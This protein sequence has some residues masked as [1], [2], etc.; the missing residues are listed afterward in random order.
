M[1]VKKTR[2]AAAAG[3]DPRYAAVAARD[4]RADG[5]FVYAVR[6]TGIY[7]R[8]GCPARPAKP[9]NIVFYDSAAAAERAGFR[10][11]KRCRP[12]KASPA[13]GRMALVAELCRVIET[14]AVPPTLAELAARAGLSPYHLH[15]VFKA[16]TGVTP[17][18]YAQEARAKR[19]RQALAHSVSVTDAI[20]DAGYGS[21]G[22]FYEKSNLL[23]G[24][25]PSHY[26]A[27]G[28]G[29]PVRFAVGECSLGAVLVAQSERGICA[30]LLGD[31]PEALLHE[32]QD[33]FANAELLG[34]DARF[35]RLVAQVVAF[36]DA[37]GARLELPLDIR[38]TAFQQRVWRAL[39][40]IPPGSTMSY[41]EI[42]RR[43][44]MPQSVRAVG[45]A[46]AANALAVVIPCHRAVRTDG[47]LSGY[48]WGIERKQALLVREKAAARGEK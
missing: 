34:G 5:Q 17:K 29:Q 19:L 3:P 1:P 16:A 30:I 13:A 38:G 26:R 28:A 46:C 4:A 2:S 43:L 10:P 9:E 11:C 18:A 27:G 37:P 32:L 21:S 8:P 47:S 23:L 22:R 45:S 44:G 15:R 14:A 35:E 7:C 6:S 31:E 39:Q 33:R 25:T 40:D 41:G 36:I 12:D 42:A 48:R 20:Y 24:M